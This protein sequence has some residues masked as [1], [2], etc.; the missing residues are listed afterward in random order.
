MFSQELKDLIYNDPRLA[1]VPII[2]MAAVISVV[3][4]AMERRFYE[5]SPFLEKHEILDEVCRR[6]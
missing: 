4:D 5:E 3:E 2:H 1:D 6:Y